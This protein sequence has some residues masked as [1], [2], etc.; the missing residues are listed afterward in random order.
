MEKM[1]F[2]EVN[3]IPS[4]LNTSAPTGVASQLAQVAE[5]DRHFDGVTIDQ[6]RGNPLYDRGDTI[7]KVG[8]AQ[9][10]IADNA[11]IVK[12]RSK[13]IRGLNDAASRMAK[14]ASK[15]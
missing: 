10:A 1:P 7:D 4:Q 13:F 12:S 11:K 2:I 15:N 6:M 8:R 9:R 14:P 5:S 3:C